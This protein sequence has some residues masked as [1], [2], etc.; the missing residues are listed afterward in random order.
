MC[1]HLWIQAAAAAAA[2]SGT[3][4]VDCDAVPAAAAVAV[5]VDVAGAIGVPAAAGDAHA[6]VAVQFQCVGGGAVRV[7]VPHQTVHQPVHCDDRL[8]R[9]AQ[10]SPDPDFVLGSS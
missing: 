4:A 8:K 2:V 10:L 5:P 3:A 9:H 1:Y 6:A 7:H